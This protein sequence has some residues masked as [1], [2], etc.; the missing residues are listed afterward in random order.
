[1]IDEADTPTIQE[2]NEALTR[3]KFA[4]GLCTD[5]RQVERIGELIKQTQDLIVDLEKGESA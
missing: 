5:A 3:L 4:H 1:M 2:L